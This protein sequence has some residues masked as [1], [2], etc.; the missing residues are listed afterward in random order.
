[1][2]TYEILSS[3]LDGICWKMVKDGLPISVCLHLQ[4][5]SLEFEN[6]E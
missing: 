1:M 4:E 2:V 5:I 6:A 3:V